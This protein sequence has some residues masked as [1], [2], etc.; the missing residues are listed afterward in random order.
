M[1]S[2]IICFY[3][4]HVCNLYVDFIINLKVKS[5]IP[6]VISKIDRVSYGLLSQTDIQVSA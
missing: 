3:F 6:H 1:K 5:F 2:F 4:A